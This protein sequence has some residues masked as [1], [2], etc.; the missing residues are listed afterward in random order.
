VRLLAQQSIFYT[1]PF[2]GYYSPYYWT[3]QSYI[4]PPYVPS[5][6]VP[7]PYEQAPVITR[8]D[9]RLAEEV[10]RLAEEVA[11]LRQEQAAAAIRET[12]P[13]PPPAPEAPAI[14]VVLV[15]RDGRR[16][17]IQ[18]YAIVGQTLWVLDEQNSRRIPLSELDL[19][20]TQRENSSRGVRF[21][22]PSR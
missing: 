19:D 14:P 13:P 4:A 1:Q 10:Q 21:A 11:Q 2:T 8:N 20:V 22:V 18:N 9:D 16:L 12:I 15:Y 17:T 6:Y 3:P 5:P 7:S